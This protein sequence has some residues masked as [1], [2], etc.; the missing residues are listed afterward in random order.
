[1][2]PLF[3]F[4]LLRESK[5]NMLQDW[6][7]GNVTV[8]TVVRSRWL[9]ELIFSV[10]MAVLLDSRK[11]FWFFHLWRQ[12]WLLFMV[13]IILT[14]HM[15]IL[16]LRGWFQLMNAQEIHWNG[17]CITLKH[18][19]IHTA[20][21]AKWVAV[22]LTVIHGAQW[23]RDRFNYND[24]NFVINQKLYDTALTW[25]LSDQSGL[26]LQ[27]CMISCSQNVTDTNS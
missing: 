19:H 14:C 24:M 23:Q 5:S 12:S 6:E 22:S 4:F 7:C 1:M 21:Q 9:I 27:T 11:S 2:I 17:S 16:F 10:L 13:L 18:M 20:P 8:V 3:C 26:I 15:S 25:L